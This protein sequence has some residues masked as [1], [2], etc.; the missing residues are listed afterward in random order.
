MSAP[1]ISSTVVAIT[2]VLN[3]LRTPD[4]LSLLVD[5][6]VRTIGDEIEAGM[7]LVAPQDSQ[8]VLAQN[9]NGE[10]LLASEY[11]NVLAIT[12]PGD[13]ALA[14]A[15]DSQCRK[16][17]LRDAAYPTRTNQYGEVYSITLMTPRSYVGPG[18]DNMGMYLYHGGYYRVR[19]VGEEIA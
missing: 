3:Q 5:Q 4:L 16:A 18:K 10:E 7:V 13:Y 15:I 6:G 17:L 9:L 19:A 1:K 14:E 11:L 2:D 12:R 8:G